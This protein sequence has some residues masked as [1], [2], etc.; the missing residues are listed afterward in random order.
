M[1]G[2]NR[3]IAL[4]NAA[5]Y[6]LVVPLRD[7]ALTYLKVFACTSQS[8]TKLM[9]LGARSDTPLSKLLLGNVR[10]K[11][12][13]LLQDNAVETLKNS[14]NAAETREE[15]Q[16][17][18]HTLLAIIQPAAQPAAPAVPATATPA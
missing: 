9:E 12:D 2:F 7:T 10:N 14:V 1:R 3:A 13:Y 18:G 8:L 4:Y 16:E 17:L 11:W 6:L 15:V 5:D